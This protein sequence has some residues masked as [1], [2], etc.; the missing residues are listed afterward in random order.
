MY[1]K[2]LSDNVHEI[3]PGASVADFP[4]EGD[5]KDN[6]DLSDLPNI[7]SYINMEEEDVGYLSLKPHHFGH[8][9]GE[10]SPPQLDHLKKSID[11]MI[12]ESTWWFEN[13]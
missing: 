9:D 5:P 7:N 11:E 13:P 8:V 4:L 2:I 6:F 10:N 3:E 12:K 1:K